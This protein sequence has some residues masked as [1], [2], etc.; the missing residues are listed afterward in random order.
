MRWFDAHPDDKHTAI[1]LETAHPAKFPDE[2]KKVVGKEPDAPL[3]LLEVEQKP[4]HYDTI[5]VRYDAFKQYLM[6][7]Y[8]K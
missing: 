3:S 5:E 2:I 8:A 7:K 1:S 4:E 6:E